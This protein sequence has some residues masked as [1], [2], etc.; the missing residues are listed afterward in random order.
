[1]CLPPP[2]AALLLKILIVRVY[3]IVVRGRR[4]AL[5]PFACRNTRQDSAPIPIDPRNV[6]AEEDRQAVPGGVGRRQSRGVEDHEEA[7]AESCERA[8]VHR[9]DG[10]RQLGQRVDASLSR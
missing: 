4:T 1:M 2:A 10:S 7:E 9:D 5:R 3:T 8:L 6:R